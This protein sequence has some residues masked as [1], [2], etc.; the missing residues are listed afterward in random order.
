[1]KLFIN[2]RGFNYGAFN[3]RSVSLRVVASKEV[4]LE[5][6]AE[7]TKYMIISRDQN[8]GQNHSIKTP[9]KFFESMKHFKY[10]AATLK[11]QN[12]VPEEVKSR[13]KSGIACYHSVQNLLS[14]SLLSKNIKGKIY[15]TTILPLI[16]YG[17]ETWPLTLRKEHRLKVFEN[18]VLGKIFEPKKDEV[19]VGGYDYIIR[20]FMFC[21]THQ[22]LFG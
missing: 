13:V 18:R 10:F 22:I 1:L 17:C 19:E 6:N 9:N 14:S 21:A 2:L 7:E 16:L 15:R 3:S 11:N 20:S 12:S 4:G 5:V 8:A